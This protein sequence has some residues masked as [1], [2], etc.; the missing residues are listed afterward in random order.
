MFVLNFRR[1]RQRNSGVLQNRPSLDNGGS[2]YCIQK[3]A[4]SL[5][6]PARKY[7]GKVVANNFR[8]SLASKS[9]FANGR[10]DDVTLFLPGLQ[11]S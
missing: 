4:P 7:T 5:G 8:G 6:I 2:L 9:G 10:N 11:Q 3:A 1:L